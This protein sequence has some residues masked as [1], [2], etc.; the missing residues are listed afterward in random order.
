M[1]FKCIKII[2]VF[3][4]LTEEHAKIRSSPKIYAPLPLYASKLGVPLKPG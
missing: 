1:S 4:P 2:L 3:L